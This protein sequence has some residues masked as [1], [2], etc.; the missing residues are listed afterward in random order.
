MQGCA[1][2][3][4]AARAVALYRRLEADT[5]VA[6]VNQGGDM[7]R[8]VLRRSIRRAGEDGARDARQVAARRAGGGALCAGQRQACRRRSELEDEMAD[9]GLDGCRPARS[10]DRLDALVWAVTELTARPRAEPRI[11]SWAA[12]G[13]WCRRGWGGEGEGGLAHANILCPLPWGERGIRSICQYKE[14]VRG[15]TF[16]FE[17]SIPLT[18]HHASRFPQCPLPPGERARR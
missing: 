14:W 12:T 18:Q 13:R 3:G 10:P 1:P 8:A 5:M 6:E 15:I 2:A 7:V 17:L 16:R 11:R 9:F 4:W